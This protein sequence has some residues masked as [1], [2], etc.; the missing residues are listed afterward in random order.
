[1]HR[2]PPDVEPVDR[3]D[4]SSRQFSHAELLHL[5]VAAIDQQE[6]DHEPNPMAA[7]T[8]AAS[9]N[10]TP[11][12]EVAALLA[13]LWPDEDQPRRP[14]AS[15]PALPMR[16]DRFEI[17]RVLGYGG[18]GVVLLAR[19]AVLG[20]E[21]ALKV[22]RPELLLARRHRQRFLREAQAAAVLQH[23]NVAPVYAVGELGPVWYITRGYVPGPTLAEWLEEQ[24]GHIEA[25]L[26]AQLM[27]Q[28][29]DAVQHAH[30]RGVLHRDLKP[31]NVL[32]EESPAA[33]GG[34]MVRLADFGL[35]RWLDDTEQLS[36]Q[37]ELLGTPSYM[38][39][40]QA[41]CRAA[42]VGVHSDIY[43]LGAILFELLC[44]ETPFAGDS[45]LQT[46]RLIEE[47]RLSPE[48]LRRAGVPRD[49]ESI[50][51]KCLAH[52]AAARYA[53]AGELLAD[54]DAFLVGQPVAARPLAWPERAASWCRRRPVVAGLA[55][56][57]GGVLVTSAVLVTWQWRQAVNYATQVERS[58]IESEQTQAH[59]AWV[60][61]EALRTPQSNDPM[62]IDIRQRLLAHY[63]GVLA[64]HSVRRPSPAF[65]AATES[66]RARVAELSDDLK[67][68]HEGYQQSI[69]RWRALLRD[70]PQ[71]GQY[72][73]ALAENLYSLHA[74]E[75]ASVDGEEA[76][77]AEAEHERRF[78][79][80]LREDDGR[81]EVCLEYLL[82]LL[83]RGEALSETGARRDALERFEWA[84][85]LGNR[86]ATAHPQNREYMYANCQAKLLWAIQ[87]RRLGGNANDLPAITI[88][89][90]QARALAEQDP[91]NEDYRLLQA[92]FC[93]LI[94]QLAA[95]RGDQQKALAY[96]EGA[97]QA[98]HSLPEERWREH[99]V[100]NVL[101]STAWNLSTL[102]EQSQK[103]QQQE[104]M[105]REAIKLAERARDGG[106]ISREN[107][108]ELGFWYQAFAESRL[109]E[110]QAEDAKL[111][112]DKAC[113][114]L[115]L[116]S[117][118]TTEVKKGRLTWAACHAAMADLELEQEQPAA[119]KAHLTAAVAI[120]EQLLQLHPRN[121]QA[122]ERLT[123]YRAALEELA[124]PAIELMGPEEA[125][126][127]QE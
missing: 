9:T 32:L 53:T 11:P 29:A 27:R 16:I 44:G 49:L 110:S 55:A 112:F 82:L 120:L 14:D 35:A 119:A 66:L 62:L 59:W 13:A 121:R 60:Q 118:R 39:P 38:A 105:L 92:H 97:Y 79:A 54:L 24:G 57:L 98:L 114:T 4:E 84:S 2:S 65:K 30:S 67:S 122:E 40:E 42:D 52:D 56:A 101:A 106:F 20:R 76:L 64:L 34:W 81:G 43:G 36:R 31:S 123:T 126:I 90:Q 51:M 94:A 103:P 8:P 75:R 125:T 71:N 78:T 89:E 74:L 83:E 113:Q 47:G 10:A 115:R 99:A 77:A 127:K 6:G 88:A 37:G 18:F 23:P 3:E 22:P 33:P 102:Y 70:S 73:R 86:L 87:L 63:T 25:R 80:L 1:M 15:L 26:G 108:G 28:V 109:R 72:R 111:A 5:L 41:A 7:L 21:V 61:D 100:E 45:D 69:A 93:R 19:D 91:L 68:A 116:T 50:C 58:L 95:E 12:D 48:R 96:H 17:V 46:L 85:R 104:A 107:L 117:G 124:T